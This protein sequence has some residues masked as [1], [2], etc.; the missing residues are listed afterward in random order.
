MAVPLR[1][2]HAEII[3]QDAAGARM[4]HRMIIAE[5]Q[6]SR[7][8]AC[9][10]AVPTVGSTPQKLEWKGT[11]PIQQENRGQHTNAGPKTIIRTCEYWI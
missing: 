11:M 4:L 8:H 10:S 1:C 5:L 2:P 7:L 9:R 6:G 3:Q